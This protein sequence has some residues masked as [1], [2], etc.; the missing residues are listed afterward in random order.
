MKKILWL[1][2]D[3]M[4][5]G[6]YRCW[7]PALALEA[8]GRYE[9]FFVD[10]SE[11]QDQHGVP[12][13]G[14]LYDID[15]LVMQ[16]AIEP[17]FL[18]WQREARLRGIPVVFETDD[19]VF[20]IARHNPVYKMWHK[21]RKLTRRLVQGADHTVVSTEPLRQSI[22][23]KGEVHASKV[24]VCHNHLHPR[25]WGAEAMSDA[26][27][28]DNKQKLV[29]GWQGSATHDV[30][31]TQALPGLSRILNEFPHV[32]IRFFGN[33]PRTVKG[34][35][36]PK[37][38]EWMPGVRFEQYPRNLLRG[39]FDIGIAPLVDS[40]FNRGKSNLK[41]LE[42][43]ACGVPVIAS[44]VYPYATT[45]R[46][47]ETGL[48]A[49]TPDEWYEHLRALVIDPDRREEIATN[50]KRFV[51]TKWSNEVKGPQWVNLFDELLGVEECQPMLSSSSCNERTPAA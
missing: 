40:R 6:V 10:H 33:V 28:F 20:H 11:C 47:G 37:R 21:H 25:V 49:S 7:L 35:I 41:F 16:R 48:L 30:D 15:L 12:K 14:N 4:A 2:A 22:I 17:I 31:F 26:V 5:C 24:T 50:A 38:F 32:T 19:D 36:P 9:N 1:S 29:I 3:R 39:N 44:P 27:I 8:T 51:W 13:L 45:I 42:Y 34:A 23:E 18:D 43:A 46:H